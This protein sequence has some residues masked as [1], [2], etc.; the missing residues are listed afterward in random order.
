MDSIIKQEVIRRCKADIARFN[1]A[2]ELQYEYASY[3][4]RI[5]LFLGISTTSFSTLSAVLAFADYQTPIIIL[6]IM[7]ATTTAVL[8]YL[9]PSQREV[10]RRNAA[11]FCE[12]YVNVVEGFVV[13]IQACNEQ[14]A[15]D[16]H[17][18]MN[19]K[20]MQLIKKIK[21]RL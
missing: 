5:H 11:G 12:Q 1:K 2:S 6:A 10:A 4:G 14:E 3:W 20:K 16:K 15:I 21:Y 9:N 13:E 19:R 18:H 8:T 7:G 17:R